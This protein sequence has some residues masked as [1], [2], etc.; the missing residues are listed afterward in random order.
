M[1]DIEAQI[2]VTVLIKNYNYESDQMQL[3][4]NVKIIIKTKLCP[5]TVESLVEMFRT[6]NNKSG[7]LKG[8]IRQR[9]FPSHSKRLISNISCELNKNRHCIL[10]TCAH[11]SAKWQISLL[12][13]CPLCIFE[14]SFYYIFDFIY[15]I[16]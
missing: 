9:L 2:T 11:S 15:P 5:H 13:T 10:C 7:I 4:V 16:K 8:K 3:N 6:F 12:D 1:I 14:V